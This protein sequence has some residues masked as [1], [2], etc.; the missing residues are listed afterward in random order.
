MTDTTISALPSREFLRHHERLLRPPLDSWAHELYEELAGLDAASAGEPSV[1][2]SVSSIMNKTSFVMAAAGDMEC[3][4]Y[5][6]ECQLRWVARRHHACLDASMLGHAFQPW[7]NVGRLHG[8][9][10]DLKRALPHFTLGEMS[11]GEMRVSLGPCLVPENSWPAIFEAAPELRDV[12]WN[13]QT[14]ETIKCYLKLN[15]FVG[16]ELALARLRDTVPDT[17][18]AFLTEG[19]IL[20]L[21]HQGHADEAVAR[22]ADGDPTSAYDEAAF[23]LHEATALVLRGDTAQARQRSVELA[24]FLTQVRPNRPKDA[25]TLLRQLRQLARLLEA[26]GEPRYALAVSIHGLDVCETHD[27]QP[28]RLRFL[29]T[30]LRLAGP[31]HPRAGAWG[32]ARRALVERSLYREIRRGPGAPLDVRRHPAFARLI[33]AVELAAAVRPTMGLGTTLR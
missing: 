24:V 1:M 19:H 18:H 12:L 31:G 4:R 27:D 9:M 11:A 21:L 23:R 3:A 8:L 26:T 15:D 10:G 16:M 30:A 22:A 20:R 28:L 25:P 5:I 29:E 2:E 13:A 14:L 6:C 33:R 17:W 32:R 7:I